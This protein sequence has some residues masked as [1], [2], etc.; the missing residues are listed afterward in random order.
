KI[1]EVILIAARHQQARL[2]IS[3]EATAGALEKHAMAD[4]VQV[5]CR[6]WRFGKSAALV[7]RDLE[8][9]AP[10]VCRNFEMGFE[11]DGC[12]FGIETVALAFGGSG[13]P[14]VDRVPRQVHGMAAHVA[15]LATAEVPMHVPMQAAALEVFRVVWMERRGPEPQIIINIAGRV[16]FGGHIAG[17][18]NNPVSKRAHLF[19]FANGAIADHFA[20]AIEV[21]VL[22]PLSAD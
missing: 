21:G 13:K 19:E 16:A 2:K 4:L 11:F 14:G 18:R 9:A 3:N 12:D 17:P 15:D 10:V 22:V 20:D 8:R 6:I 1:R 5:N 7:P